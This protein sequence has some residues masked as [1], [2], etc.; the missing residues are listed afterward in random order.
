MS[1]VSRGR[2]VSLMFADFILTFL[3]YDQCGCERRRI[4][5]LCYNAIVVRK[6]SVLVDSSYMSSSGMKG[7]KYV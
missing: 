2:Y 3:I 6:L 1:L 4:L 5:L 7:I